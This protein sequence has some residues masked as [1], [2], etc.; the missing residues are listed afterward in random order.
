MK[1]NEAIGQRRLGVNYWLLMYSTGGN[2]AI[3]SPL[4][5][6]ANNR[7]F[8]GL[9]GVGEVLTAP[10]RNVSRDL[11]I[12]PLTPQIL[13]IPKHRHPNSEA[14]TELVASSFKSVRYP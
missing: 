2:A 11:F 8:G 13:E 7:N 3:V 9:F 12:K 1:I 10:H 6:K 5:V 14:S 4:S